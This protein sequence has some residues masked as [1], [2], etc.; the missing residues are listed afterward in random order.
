MTR[1]LIVE[2]DLDTREGLASM[3]GAAG[4]EAVPVGRYEDAIAVL[5]GRDGAGRV[6]DV[7]L[8]DV[9]L[10]DGDG[11]MIV[12]HCARRAPPIPCVV[13]TGDRGAP[14]MKRASGAFEVLVK[15]ASPE[16]LLETVSAAAG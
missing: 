15:P 14:S 10:E 8:T 5:E 7:V 9:L 16:L 6:P 11:W 12:R 13:V 3:F 4:L 1:V 2:D